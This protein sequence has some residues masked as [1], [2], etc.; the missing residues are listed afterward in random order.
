MRF[1]VA[2]A[3]VGTWLAAG[4]AALATAA[5]VRIVAAGD[6][7]W[8]GMAFTVDA[9]PAAAA[10]LLL[11]VFPAAAVY[12]RTERRGD[13]TRLLVAAAALAVLIA[14]VVVIHTLPH[15]GE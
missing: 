1:V 13:L 15:R 5:F 12:G 8:G 10:V 11:G 7:G 6:D 9:L 3:R 14:E 2:L 4:I